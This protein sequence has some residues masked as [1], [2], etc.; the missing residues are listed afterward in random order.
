MNIPQRKR[1]FEFGEDAIAE[2]ILDVLRTNS[3]EYLSTSKVLDG[4]GLPRSREGTTH[5]PER[6]ICDGVLY[7]MAE[8]RDDVEMM[9]RTH[10][11]QAYKW[12]Y[13]S[14]G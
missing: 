12:R 10:N 8:R 13:V 7:R 3:P 4:L 2:A 14:G 6:R 5:N 11:R 1:R 9:P